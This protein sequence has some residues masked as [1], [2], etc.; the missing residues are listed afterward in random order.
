[1]DK[2]HQGGATIRKVEVKPSSIS[3]NGT[4]A[5]EKISQGELITTLTGSPFTTQELQEFYRGRVPDDPLQ[6]DHHL[7]L[8][9]NY[10]SKVI[11]HSCDPNS[12]LRNTSDLY[13][14]KDIQIGDEITYDY[15]A[16]VGIHDDWRMDCNCRSPNC[17]KKL[18][19]ILTLPPSVLNKYLSLNAI[20]DFIKEELRE[21]S[22]E[23]E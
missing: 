5:K 2:G 15:S 13:A 9:L 1:M 3:G 6:I 19:N 7:Y 8:I 23:N 18:G 16:T 22:H 20:Q 4:F 11:N 14:L 12:C 10:K 21:L 17:R